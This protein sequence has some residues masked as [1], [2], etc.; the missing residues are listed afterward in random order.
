MNDKTFEKKVDRD[1][2]QVKKDITALGEDNVSGMAKIKKGLVTLGEDGVTGLSRKFEQLAGD[3]KEKVTDATKTVNKDVGHRLSQYN[4]KV[5]DVVDRVPGSL[6]KKAAG[7]PWVTITVSLAF[8]L[9]LGVILLLL[10]PN[11]KP[12]HNSGFEF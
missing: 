4:S 10:K 1:V 12:L 5:Q 8:G 7:Y 3:T 2:D 6:G 9:V 11:R